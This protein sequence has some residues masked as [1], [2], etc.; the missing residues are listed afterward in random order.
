MVINIYTHAHAHAHTHTHTPH[1]HV[2]HGGKYAYISNTRT[3]ETHI[4]PKFSYLYSHPGKYTNN[5]KIA[6]AIAIA[7]AKPKNEK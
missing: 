2:V 7:I 6:N 5:P 3:Q 1:R 4:L